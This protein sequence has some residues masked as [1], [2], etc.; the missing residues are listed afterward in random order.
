MTADAAEVSAVWIAIVNSSIK[1]NPSVISVMP[2]KTRLFLAF[3]TLVLMLVVTAATGWW[4]VSSLNSLAVASIDGDV[5]LAQIVGDLDSQVL[6]LRRY[7]KDTF[8]NIGSPEKISDYYGKWQDTLQALRDNTARARPLIPEVEQSTVSGF[9][10]AVQSYEQGMIDVH[11]QIVAG[12]ITTSPQANSEMSRYKDYIRGTEEQ[13]AQIK[14]SSVKR[15]EAIKPDMQLRR[16]SI[17]ATLLTLTM[18]ATL[19]ASMLAYRITKR[20]TS[21]LNEAMQL[22]KKVAAGELG[23]AMGVTTTDELGELTRALHEMDHRLSMIITDVSHAAVTVSSASLQIAA[24]ND[25][26]STRTQEQASSLEETA[27]SMEEM[28]ATVKQNADSTAHATELARRARKTADEG[29]RVVQQAIAAMEEI[30]ASSKR[31]GDIIGV[32]DE[33]AFQTNLLALNAAVEAARAGEQGRGFAVV[34]AEVRNLA[35]RSAGAAKE[36]K[37][38][39]N[40]STGKVQAGAKLVEQSGLSLTEIVTS[41]QQVSVVV[42]EIAAATKE[43]SAG[44]MQINHVI[45]QVDTM[46]QQNA[47]AVE[48]VSAASKALQGQAELLAS[49][50]SQFHVNGAVAAKQ[51]PAAPMSASMEQSEAQSWAA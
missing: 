10:S 3:G 18:V 34:A 28:T 38:L 44:V 51:R 15:V 29:G 12:K 21:T 32:I 13:L 35:Q 25:Q 41:T 49:R 20:I 5:A 40:D 8:L 6:T 33:I 11:A 46:T 27:A 31:I 1:N 42:D 17:V 30:N 16:H 26:L 50:V 4:G 37:S 39:I 7:E 24:G 2:I 23:H 48:E 9:L 36:I 19:V 45:T 43:Q 47:A 22:A 14:K